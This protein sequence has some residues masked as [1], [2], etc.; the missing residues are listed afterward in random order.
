VEDS[1]V[2]FD[3]DDPLIFPADLLKIGT[4]VYLLKPKGKKK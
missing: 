2:E 1:K 3:V 4:E